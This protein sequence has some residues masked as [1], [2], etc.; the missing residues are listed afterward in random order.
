LRGGLRRLCEAEPALPD[1]MHPRHGRQQQ[2]RQRDPE[3]EKLPDQQNAAKL[4]GKNE[5]YD[6]RQAGHE[7]TFNVEGRFGPRIIPPI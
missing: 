3:P 5:N 4:G 7:I 1:E 6:Q 2:Q